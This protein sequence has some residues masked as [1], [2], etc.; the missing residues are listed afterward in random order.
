[1][2]EKS[3]GECQRA[4]KAKLW[5]V[6]LLGISTA[7]VF[8]ATLLATNRVLRPTDGCDDYCCGGSGC[9]GCPPGC[10]CPPFGTS[11]PCGTLS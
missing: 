8:C 11:G 3:E 6:L 9:S 7:S 4:E 10:H 5:G 2:I 1:M